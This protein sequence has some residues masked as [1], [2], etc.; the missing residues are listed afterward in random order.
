MSK[1]ATG[2]WARLGVSVLKRLGS[3][4]Q[5]RHSIT[6][7]DGTMSRATR[8]HVQLTGTQLDRITALELDAERTLPTQEKLVLVVLVPWELTAQTRDADDRVVRG[9]EILWL[10]WLGYAAQDLRDIHDM[11]HDDLR[12]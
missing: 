4:E 3:L 9:D 11:G 5:Q 2:T 6:L 7:R 10:E 1:I 8:Y 12:D